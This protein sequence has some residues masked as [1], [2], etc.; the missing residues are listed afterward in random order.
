MKSLGGPKL[1][2]RG[3]KKDST[4]MTMNP[5]CDDDDDDEE[6][7]EADGGNVADRKEKDGASFRSDRRIVRL[8]IA[9]YWADNLIARYKASKE[10]EQQQPLTEAIVTQEEDGEG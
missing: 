9:R 6:E 2:D 4:T 7:G 10:D 8:L 3:L 5:D 1:L